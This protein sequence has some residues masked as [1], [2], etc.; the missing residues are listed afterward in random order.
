MSPPTSSPPLSASAAYA[1]RLS[2]S[3]SIRPFQA[4]RSDKP[5]SA[6]DDPNTAQ[7]AAKAKMLYAWWTF[8]QGIILVGWVMA[9][10]RVVLTWYPPDNWGKTA[11]DAIAEAAADNLSAAPLQVATVSGSQTTAP[12]R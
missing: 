4:G 8:V 1:R 2:P 6:W 3:D 12:A 5:P 11:A 7:G 10:T 9:G